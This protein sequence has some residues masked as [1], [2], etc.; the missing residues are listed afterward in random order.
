[1]ARGPI[2]D[3]PRMRPDARVVREKIRAFYAMPGHGVGGALHIVTDDHNL[4][5]QFIRHCR[6]IAENGGDWP[7][8]C[9]HV[10]CLPAIEIADDLLAM[11]RTQRKRAVSRRTD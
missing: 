6:A 7:C 4:A 2:P 1:M 9:G 11:T 8:H 3:K 10:P 5:D